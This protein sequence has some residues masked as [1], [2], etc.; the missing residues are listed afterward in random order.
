MFLF[1]LLHIFIFFLFS[2]L[3]WVNATQ[4]FMLMAYIFG[5]FLLIIMIIFRKEFRHNQ[6]GY[7]SDRVSQ[8]TF[9]FIIAGLIL[10]FCCKKIFCFSLSQIIIFI[11]Y[12]V[13]FSLIGV[14]IFGGEVFP[15]SITVNWG[16]IV[17]VIAMVLFLIAAIL[18]ILDGIHSEKQI[19]LVLRNKIN[20]FSL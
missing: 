10:F 5:M 8:P 16:Y 3:A 17:A 6:G 12:L 2:R 14:S 11:D 4:A 19:S 13:I 7:H 20:F 18:F 15:N 1:I 9:T